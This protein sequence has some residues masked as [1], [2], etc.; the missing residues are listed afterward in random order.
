MI[1]PSRPAPLKPHNVHRQLVMQFVCP[2][3]LR[4][5]RCPMETK[6]N[7]QLAS[8]VRHW[9]S[10]QVPDY[11]VGVHQPTGVQARSRPTT[12]LYS[13]SLWPQALIGFRAA[14]VPYRTTVSLARYSA[15]PPL[16]TPFG[17]GPPPSAQPRGGGPHAS[18]SLL[19]TRME[20]GAGRSHAA[21]A[22]GPS[23]LGAGPAPM[24]LTVG[25]SCCVTGP[26]VAQLGHALLLLPGAAASPV[27]HAWPPSCDH[28]HSAVQA[29]RSVAGRGPLRLPC[30]PSPPP[31]AARSH[32]PLG[33]SSGYTLALGSTPHLG[34]AVRSCP[35]PGFGLHSNSVG[36][37]V[38]PVSLQ[39]R[40]APGY[41]HWWGRGGRPA[42][43]LAPCTPP[44]KGGQWTRQRLHAASAAPKQLRGPQLQAPHG[45]RRPPRVRW[46]GLRSTVLRSTPHFYRASRLAVL[47]LSPH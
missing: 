30:T 17:Q 21:R 32:S 10:L 6:V 13:V 44:D 22:S 19:S 28:C 4:Y 23:E 34:Y 35:P 20:G 40:P 26:L 29:L 37:S 25:C 41:S 8:I 16:V 38:P 42:Q 47:I 45:I 27:S 9:A 33:R 36:A 2:L 1:C 39:R 5:F 7:V 12:T 3:R 24:R 31:A 46:L 43:H 18:H 11:W 14:A 15:R